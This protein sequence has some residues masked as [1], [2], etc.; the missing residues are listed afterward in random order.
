MARK[1]F[2]HLVVGSSVPVE[3]VRWDGSSADLTVE[4]TVTGTVVEVGKNRLTLR[5]PYLG[6]Q[7]RVVVSMQTGM[8]WGS[9]V[10]HGC[11]RIAPGCATKKVVSVK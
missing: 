11:Y 8:E 4:G 10:E 7:A 1:T 2:H 6:A 5:V 9:Q 3:H